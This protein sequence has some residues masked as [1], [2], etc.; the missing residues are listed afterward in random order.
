M[1]NAEELLQIAKKLATQNTEAISVIGAR[2]IVLT[3]FLDAVLPYLT[4]SQSAMIS[5]SFRL[6]ID[7]VLSLM[8]ELPV[9]SEY[10]AT[11]EGM[12]ESILKTLK[13]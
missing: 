8:D 7:E 10:R 13:G 4:P 9:P 5:H 12:T 6:G 11:L 1:N 3:K 2:A